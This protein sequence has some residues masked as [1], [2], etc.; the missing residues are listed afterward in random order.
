[1][2]NQHT[3]PDQPKA[4]EDCH[5][6]LAWIIPKLDQFPRQRRFTLGERIETG[7]LQVLEQLIKAS[8]QHAETQS[9][10]TANL[11]LDVVRHLWRLSH[12]LHAISTQSYGQGAERL[13]DLGRQIGG[14]RKHRESIKHT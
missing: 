7:L 5:A 10:K 2:P 13:T 1:M 12:T 9:L 3:Q 14:W 4:V 11:Q 6:L 8:Y